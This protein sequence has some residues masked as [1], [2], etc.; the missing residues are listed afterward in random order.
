MPKI[1]VTLTDELISALDE[2]S[3]RRGRSA[4]LER[5]AWIGLGGRGGRGFAGAEPPAPV[6]RTP[7]SG[8]AVSLGSAK[9]RS[10]T[11]TTMGTTPRT[12]EVV[13]DKMVPVSK[14]TIWDRFRGMPAGPSDPV[15][16]PPGTRLKN[17]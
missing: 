13:A 7:S 5:A 4:T 17:R 14:P 8:R 16:P 10:V 9:K 11:V 1:L 15:A 3:E 12:V 6:P 2:R